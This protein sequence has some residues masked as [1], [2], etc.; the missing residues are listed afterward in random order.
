VNKNT[1]PEP[2]PTATGFGVR[3]ALAALRKHNIPVGPLLLRAGLPEPTFATSSHR[4][5][6]TAQGEFLEY[7]AVAI[8]DSAFGL[9]LAQQSDPREAGLI[10]YVATAATNL[11]DAL[12]LFARYFRIVNESVRFTLTH[13]PEGLVLGFSLVGVSQHRVKQHTEFWLALIVKAARGVTG[14]DVRPIRVACTHPRSENLDEFERF[15]GCPLEFLAPAGEVEFSSETAAL[16]LVTG[17]PHL[18]EI[19][20]YFCEGAERHRN[21]TVGSLRAAVETEVVRFLPHAQANA[22]TIARALSLSVGTLSRRLSEEGTS[23]GA[24]VEQLRQSLALEYLKYPGFTLAQ[25][26]W[27]LGYERPT[28]FRQ[29]FKRWTGR[30]P[31]TFRAANDEDSSSRSEKHEVFG[32]RPLIGK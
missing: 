11:G 22:E 2:L 26:A 1:T 12:A 4:V 16:P 31:S 23:F 28:T 7:A 8:G 13:R 30:S 14:C 17:D 24:I 9:H 10:F 19:L 25:I 18:L 29:A 3:C 5:P 15:F 21:T 20:R 32:K 6:A 27:L